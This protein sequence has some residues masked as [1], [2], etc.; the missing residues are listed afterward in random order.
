MLA[1][2]FMRKGTYPIWP[3][4]ADFLGKEI[5]IKNPGYIVQGLLIAVERLSEEGPELLILKTKEEAWLIL[6]SWSV[7]AIPSLGQK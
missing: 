6:K 3:A 5:E 7:I 1:E 2:K 4:L